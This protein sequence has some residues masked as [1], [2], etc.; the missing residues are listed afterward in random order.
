[1]PNEKKEIMNVNTCKWLNN[2]HC[3]FVFY[4]DNLTCYFNLL[5]LKLKLK[6][7]EHSYNTFIIF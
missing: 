2:I 3:L 4:H 1:M 7:L 6:K 5:K